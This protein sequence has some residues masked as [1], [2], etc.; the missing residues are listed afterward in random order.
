MRQL[1]PHQV[2]AE[3]RRPADL[4]LDEG[5]EISRKALRLQT[6][7]CNSW[8]EVIESQRSIA[9]SLPQLMSGNCWYGRGGTWSGDRNEGAGCPTGVKERI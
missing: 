5:R 2:L 9:C 4:V 3:K 8:L 6:L 1:V 7:A